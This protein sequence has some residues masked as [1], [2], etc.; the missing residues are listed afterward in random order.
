MIDSSAMAAGAAFAGLES[1]S[2]YKWPSWAQQTLTVLSRVLAG[3]LEV[4]VRSW[5]WPRAM[6]VATPCA[7]CGAC[8]SRKG[9]G[10]G[11]STMIDVRVSGKPSFTWMLLTPE[12]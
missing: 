2:L 4:A 5:G 6:I 10:G 7:T 3:V 1:G 12:L 11:P 9:R 8:G